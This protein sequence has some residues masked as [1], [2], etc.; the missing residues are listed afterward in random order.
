MAGRDVVW[1]ANA[2]QSWGVDSNATAGSA[3]EEF[4]VLVVESSVDVTTAK[5]LLEHQKQSRKVENAP[6]RSIKVLQKLSKINPHFV[7]DDYRGAI[8]DFLEVGGNSGIIQYLLRDFWQDTVKSAKTKLF[9]KRNGIVDED[10]YAFVENLLD[11]TIQSSK[12][13]IETSW[14]DVIGVMT[15][16]SRKDNLN[17]HLDG[18]I[19]REDLPLA[20][21]LLQRSADP[22]LCVQAIQSA[23]FSDKR[24]LVRLILRSRIS[25]RKDVLGE[26]LLASMSLS[27]TQILQLL[28]TYGADVNQHDAIALYRAIDMQRLGVILMIL[29][30][31]C[32]PTPTN[33][34]RA[35]GHLF[36]PE[37]AIDTRKRYEFLEVLLHGGAAGDHISQALVLAVRQEDWDAGALLISRGASTRY[38]DGEAFLHA[39]SNGKLEVLRS[40]EQSLVGSLIA[41]KAF[42]IVLQDT[43]LA[44]DLRIEL[45]RT[46]L[47][48][49]AQ[50]KPVH[51]G[52]IAAV[53][54]QDIQATRILLDNH[55][56]VNHCSAEALRL[57]ITTEQWHLVELLLRQKPSRESLRQI[58]PSIQCINR[59]ER[60]RF[61]EQ[62]LVAGVRGDVVD[63]ALFQALSKSLRDR[64]H[65]LIEILVCHGANVNQ[66]NGSLIRD[67]VLEDDEMGVKILLK[68]SCSNETLCAALAPALERN[69]T[70]V[71]LK[72][73]QLLLEAG[74][75]GDTVSDMLI[76]AVDKNDE[77][78]AHLLLRSGKSDVNFRQGNAVQKATALSTL[79]FF[80]LL[81]QYGTLDPQTKRN[82]FL[83]VLGLPRSGFY[84]RDKIQKLLPLADNKG[85]LNECVALEVDSLERAHQD[86]PEILSLL[87]DTGAAADHEILWRILG[88]KAY[89]CLE[90]VLKALPYQKDVDE[91]FL[92]SND[93]QAAQLLLSAGV[94]SNIK[95]TVLVRAVDSRPRDVVWI[96]RLLD[97][98]ASVDYDHGSAVT[99]AAARDPDEALLG[100]LLSKWPTPSTL[101]AAFTA[102]VS[103]PQ[104]TLKVSIYHLLL[105]AGVSGQPVD[106]A[107][108]S[109]AKSD[110]QDLELSKILIAF[111]ASVDH[112]QG[113]AILI[114][115]HQGHLPLLTLL[116]GQSPSEKTLFIAFDAAMHTQNADL[117]EKIYDLLLRAGVR[118]RQLDE[119]LIQATALGHSSLGLCDLLLEYNASVNYREAAAL[120]ATI[121]GSPCCQPLLYLLLEH[122][123][124]QKTIYAALCSCV[125]SNAE[126]RSTIMEICLSR[127]T[128]AI[129]GIDSV[130]FK[131]VSPTFH[132]R[133][134]DLHFDTT[135][136]PYS[137]H[138]YEY[139]HMVVHK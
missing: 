23:I 133:V 35:V 101:E 9:E 127:S 135:C 68:G 87:F 111:R 8:R 114:A 51:D 32:F 66:E 134:R 47:K 46:T 105:D 3:V 137:G 112:D 12:H 62:L 11:V 49:G 15:G 103:I 79:K 89:C 102:A 73:V 27:S 86:Q 84:R 123:P 95:G 74:A 104:I 16:Y 61:T 37:R 30:A 40:F 31:K 125:A 41:T 85:L 58:F 59:P 34:D 81:V 97:H 82:A 42:S 56:S 131:L 110:S 28:L 19:Q 118:G 99:S 14:L 129:P 26:C 21:I 83:A 90:R 138:V 122:S 109:A 88:M 139:T 78:L 92:H 72:Y 120:C 29:T 108:V 69:G 17:K 100:L 2:A 6:S 128:G 44:G 52:L 126:E 4:R 53:K 113:A 64:D 136:S 94:S 71:P 55:A 36:K 76:Y 117:Q 80:A 54:D 25:W 119:A 33:V 50:G 38:K 7:Y 106:E 75:D 107:L 24:E 121:S 91:A 96:T 116:L 39:V 115:I 10:K 13:T 63:D 5:G 57:A 130:L 60:R 65:R 124:S 45:F 1:L 22:N 132:S 48:H 70:I 20:K 18:A 93:K 98:G 67:L 43:G 77:E